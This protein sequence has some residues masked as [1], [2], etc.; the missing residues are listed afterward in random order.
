MIALAIVAAVSPCW[1]LS[2]FRQGFLAQAHHLGWAPS[3]ALT[4][5][6]S[7]SNPLSFSRELD[8]GGRENRPR[9]LS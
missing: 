3:L 6:A 4:F 8:V 9:V 1:I 2:G 7:Y 5:S